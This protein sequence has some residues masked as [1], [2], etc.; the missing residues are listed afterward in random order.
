MLPIKY[1]VKSTISSPDKVF[2]ESRTFNNKND[3]WVVATNYG[4]V[5][6]KTGKFVLEPMPSNRSDQ[7]IKATRFNSAEDALDVYRGFYE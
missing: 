3:K 6:S 7:F 5:M 2:I 1:I 4:E